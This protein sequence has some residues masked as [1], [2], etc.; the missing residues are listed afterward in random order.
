MD[1]DTHKTHINTHRNT[2]RNAHRNTD[3]HTERKVK[4]ERPTFLSNENV[5]FKTL[6]IFGPIISLQR[7]G[8]IFPHEN[9]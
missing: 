1:T 5:Y 9:F 4:T 3:T 6:I 8:N 7:H 2:H